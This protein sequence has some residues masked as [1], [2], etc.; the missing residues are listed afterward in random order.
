VRVF[1]DLST[2]GSILTISRRIEAEDL[3]F[4]QLAII[5]K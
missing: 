1:G 3:P 5:A 2:M 4:I